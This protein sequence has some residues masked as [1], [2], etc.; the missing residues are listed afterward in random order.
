MHLLLLA[1][2]RKISNLTSHTVLENKNQA[3][4]RC[5]CPVHWEERH[6]PRKRRQRIPKIKVINQNG[7]QK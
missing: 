5:W 6:I 1:Q 4:A 7:V 2:K 3:E